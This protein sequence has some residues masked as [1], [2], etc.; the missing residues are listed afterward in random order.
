MIR[1]GIVGSNYGRTVQLPAFRVDPRCSVVALAGTDETRAAELARQCAVSKSYGDWLKLV[2]DERI[3]AVAIA[4]PPQHQ[5]TIA[6]RAMS[7]GKAVFLEK[8]MAADLNSAAAMAAAA[9]KFAV[10]TVVDFNFSEVMAWRKTKALIDDGTI[11]RLRHVVATWNVENQSTRLRLHNW[12]TS[13]HEGGGILGNFAS[14]CFHYLEWF[15]GPIIALSARLFALPSDLQ[16]ESTAALTM[17]FGSGAAGIL[18][19][20]CGSYLGSGHRLEFYGDEGTLV[21]ANPTTDYM[22]GFVLSHGRRPDLTLAP[23]TVDDLRDEQFED[24]RIAPVSRLI[25]RFIDAIEQGRTARPGIAEGYRVQLLLDAARRSHALGRWID[26][27]PIN[28]PLE[29]HE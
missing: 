27:D 18:A 9:A 17:A 13:A 26:V 28:A 21:L 3:D 5:S 7:L 6:L 20:S 14:H 2:E 19:M 1:V 12:K 25:T 11:G 24:G 8:P 10:C 23:I 29:H 22:R 4:T 15:C 16:I